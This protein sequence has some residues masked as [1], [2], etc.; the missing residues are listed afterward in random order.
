[1]NKKSECKIIQDL[2]PN[3]IENLTSDETNEYIQHHLNDCD[4]CNKVYLN[5]ISE[6]NKS[7]SVEEKGKVDYLKKFRKKF[8][9]LRTM[10]L[11]ILCLFIALTTR[12]VIILSDLSN[13]ANNSI[14]KNNFY[15]KVESLANG[16]F[17]VW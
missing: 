13:K 9:I 12:K 8:K 6:D 11:I 2:L 4:E 7:K 15:Y 1:M 16:N 17:K 14:N 5:M 3:Y 10:L